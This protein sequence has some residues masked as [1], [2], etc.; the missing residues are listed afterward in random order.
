MIS[1][2]LDSYEAPDTG[3]DTST[4]VIFWEND[5]FVELLVSVSV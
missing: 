1:E 2:L 3:T 5:N 4:L